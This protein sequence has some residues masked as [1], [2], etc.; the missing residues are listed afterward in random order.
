MMVLHILIK[1]GDKVIDEN[2]SKLEHDWKNELK[3]ELKL[4]GMGS[5]EIYK[6]INDGFVEYDVH[7]ITIKAEVKEQK[8]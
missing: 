1:E 2:W 5:F 8:E 4:P 3:K 7:G 6:L